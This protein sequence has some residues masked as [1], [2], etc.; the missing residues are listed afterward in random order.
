M[1]RIQNRTTTTQPQ[2]IDSAYFN[3]TFL[4]DETILAA[5]ELQLPSVPTTPTKVKVTVN[6][7]P[8]Q[9]YNTDFVVTGDIVSWDGLGIETGLTLGDYLIITYVR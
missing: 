8:E 7:G 2:S 9:V 1:A 6:H 4:I 5:K 3:E